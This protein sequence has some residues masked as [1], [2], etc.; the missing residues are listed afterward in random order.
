MDLI[1]ANKL[2]EPLVE[3]AAS[4]LFYSD[5]S[6][7]HKNTSTIVQ[8]EKKL[9]MERL[10]EWAYMQKVLSFDMCQQYCW[11]VLAPIK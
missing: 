2:I 7:L 9:L 4:E 1:K 8:L 11:Q 5:K 10:L 3:S 6:I